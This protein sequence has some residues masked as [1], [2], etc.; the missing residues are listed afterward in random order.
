M[1]FDAVAIDPVGDDVADQN[2]VA[3]F[4]GKVVPFVI[5]DAADRRRAVIVADHF[6]AEAESV[7]RLAEAWVIRPAQEHV[8]RFAMTIGRIKIAQRVEAKPERIDLPMSELFDVRTVNPHSVDVPRVER[9][10][11]VVAPFDGRIIGKA[12][13]GVNPAVETPGERVR[14]AVGVAKTDALIKDISFV[15]FIVAVGIDEVIDIRNSM[16]ERRRR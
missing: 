5:D 2:V 11:L 16:D 4:G 7:V 6:R 10:P 8:D 14:H 9:N 15:D 13:A 12:V 3:K 1:P